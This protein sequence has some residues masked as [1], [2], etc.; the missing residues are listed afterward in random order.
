MT[1]FVA[2]VSK[3][4]PWHVTAFH[5]DYKMTEPATT[6]PAML[7]RAAE[8]AQAAGLRYVY[9]GNVPGRVGD[10]EHT[11][12]HAC[13]ERVITRYGYVIQEYR[14]TPDGACPRC[15]TRIPGRWSAAFQGQ[16]TTLP[17]RPHDR[18]RL[19]VL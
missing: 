14:L 13:G 5:R 16:R 9:A 1:E 3:D 7:R 11:Q 12:C 4:I 10:L 18:S 15:A 17:F 2:G 8:I 6:T 19:P